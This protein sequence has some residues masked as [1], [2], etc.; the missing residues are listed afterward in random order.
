[1][2]IDWKVKTML[3]CGVVGAAAGLIGA[4]I[5]VQQ[6]EKNET[7]PQ[8]TAGD[9]VKIGLSMLAVLKLLAD[10]GSR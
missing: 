5:L 10:T 2:N 1:M 7:V 4:L 6:S 3:I 8:L 9:G